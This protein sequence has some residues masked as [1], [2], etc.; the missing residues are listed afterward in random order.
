MKN[1]LHIKNMVC[2][3]CITV[4]QNGM[5]NL[6]IDIV[7][8]SLGEV[9]VEDINSI[10]KDDLTHFLNQNGFELLEDKSLQLVNSIKTHLIELIYSKVIG[11]LKVNISTYLAEKIN[12]DY[13][14]M[15]NLFSSAEGVTIEHFF[16]IQKI[17]RVKELLVY[18]ELNLT[19]ITYELG[20]SSTGHLSRQF[21][22]IIG[23]TPSQFK[24]NNK[25]KRNSIDLTNRNYANLI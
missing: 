14:Y 22:S 3:R 25:G 17:E 18:D 8:I 24:K 4:I 5:T 15:S 21:K 12:K 16:I 7:S 2:P 10:N 11:E 9:V 20:Y 1:T 6:G 13:S 23:L 19:E